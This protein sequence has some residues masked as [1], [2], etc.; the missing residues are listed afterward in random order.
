MQP[1]VVPVAFEFD[2]TYI[3]FGGWN[4]KNSLKFKNILKNNKVAFVV[5][6]LISITPWKPRGI[7]VRGMAEILR[8][9][10]Y[11]KIVPFKKL[12]WGF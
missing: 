7:E 4:L 8:G 1:H 6:D 5:D 3:Y 12:S 10:D 2:G 9:N 11:I